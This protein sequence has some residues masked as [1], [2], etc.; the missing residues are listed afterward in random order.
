MQWAGRGV[1][2]LDRV[3]FAVKDMWKSCGGGA[4]YAMKSATFHDYSL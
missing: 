3:R 4:D 2:A 1:H